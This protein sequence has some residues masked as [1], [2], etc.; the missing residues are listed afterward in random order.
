MIFTLLALS[1]FT[2]FNVN[3]RDTKAGSMIQEAVAGAVQIITIDDLSIAAPLPEPAPTPVV[4][5]NLIDPVAFVSYAKKFEGTPYVYGSTNPAVGFDCSGFINHVANHFGIKVPRSSVDFTNLGTEVSTASAQ[6][7]D[8]ILF[9]GTDASVRRVGHI[10][11]VTGQ[12]GG[13]IEF[14]HSSSG[15]AKG[16]TTSAMSEYYKTR[17]VKV[18][19]LFP[20]N[21]G[22]SAA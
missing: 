16:V 14:I 19:R 2:S 6:P 21:S 3:T 11:I 13:E 15:N 12:P 22:S 18:I 7:G 20:L 9:T 1:L 5:S 4:S 10:G 17:F 8:L